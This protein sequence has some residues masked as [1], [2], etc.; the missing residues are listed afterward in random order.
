[1]HVFRLS[2]YQDCN[3][4][5][6]PQLNCQPLDWVDI[7]YN[8]N[9]YNNFFLFSRPDLAIHGQTAVKNYE[10]CKSYILDNP[11]YP[12]VRN[13]LSRQVRTHTCFSYCTN[14]ED[15]AVLGD[16]RAECV[17]LEPLERDQIICVAP[18][19]QCERTSVAGEV[20]LSADQSPDYTFSPLQ[21]FY[22]MLIANPI[23]FIF[24]MLCIYLQTMKVN[25]DL[26][27]QNCKLL[28]F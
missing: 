4:A 8:R 21:G 3:N 7:F 19:D 1:M 22:A 9:Q 26:V 23:M 13:E 15:A 10:R 6:F 5:F 14:G 17:D 2:C 25:Q 18:T 16:D 28:S 11:S 27:K 20:Y 24:D 12:M